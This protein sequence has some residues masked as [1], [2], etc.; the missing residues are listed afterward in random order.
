MRN[1]ETPSDGIAW[2]V[3][4][5]DQVTTKQPAL[6]CARALEIAPDN[7]EARFDLGEAERALGN[8]SA[9][10]LLSRELQAD[11]PESDLGYVLEADLLGDAGD[12]AGAARLF[13]R[14]YERRATFELAAR[15]HGARRAAGMADTVAPLE[16]WLAD[17]PN[18]AG[19]LLLL[20][21]AHQ[22]AGR[23]DDALAAYERVIA[24]EPAN[25]I[26]LNNAAWLHNEAGN[27]LALD[28][29]RRAYE[30]APDVPAVLD[31]YGW[32]LLGRGDVDAA[33]AHLRKA[34]LGAPD[35]AD[36]QY[37]FA[38]GLARGGRNRRGASSARVVTQRWAHIHFPR[39]SRS[40]ARGS[41]NR[42]ESRGER[43]AICSEMGRRHC[44]RQRSGRVCGWRQSAAQRPARRRRKCGVN[45]YIIG[46]G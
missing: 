13:E 28:Y 30:Q 7:A 14:A 38:A 31:T 44:I 46:P 25:L 1:P 9:A 26:A 3:C 12:H 37:H 27:D 40:V 22:T 32:V 33:V 45:E 21:E 39:A 29:S 43:Y 36:I 35:S 10:R 24:A 6:H 5:R 8:A 4:S 34:A 42:I 18:H 16:R 20:A 2:P 17:V 11:F 19:A 23:P 15:A 41:L